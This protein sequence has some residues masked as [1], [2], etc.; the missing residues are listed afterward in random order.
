MLPETSTSN[1]SSTSTTT[2]RAPVDA[3]APIAKAA[4]AATAVEARFFRFLI[5]LPSWL[6]EIVQVYCSNRRPAVYQA[7][8][9]PT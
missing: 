3:K 4:T 9:V 2:A 1:C 7:I 6:Y 8:S 5:S